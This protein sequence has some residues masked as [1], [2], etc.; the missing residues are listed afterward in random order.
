M[1]GGGAG[2]IQDMN[3]RMRDNKK[4]RSKRKTTQEKHAK[5][6]DQ[7]NRSSQPLEFNSNVAQY[8]KVKKRIQKRRNKDRRITQIIFLVSV[9]VIIAL[10]SVQLINWNDE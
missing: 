10:I 5:I 1:L 9:L 4:L 2:H 7:S 6:T 8:N 3:N